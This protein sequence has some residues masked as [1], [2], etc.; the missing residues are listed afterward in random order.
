MVKI[1]LIEVLIHHPRTHF[2][3]ILLLQN[4]IDPFGSHF[5]SLA[6]SVHLIHGGSSDTDNQN[7][8]ITIAK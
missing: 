3:N 8:N 7:S 1:N 4:D 6:A 2:H 5:V